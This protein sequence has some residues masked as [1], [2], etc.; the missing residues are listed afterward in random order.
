MNLRVMTYNIQHAMEHAA[1]LKDKTEIINFDMIA[2]VIRRFN[3]DVVGLN[4]VRDRGAD[5]DYREQTL[6][7]ARRLGYEHCYFAKAIDFGYG[8]YGNAIISKYPMQSARTIAI[9]DP[10]YKNSGGYYETRCILKAEFEVP[11]RFDVLISHFGLPAS[12]QRNAVS[13]MM[14]LLENRSVPT[15]AMGD[16][17]M[18]PENPTLAP[19]LAALTDTAAWL[20]EGTMTF[21]TENP[22]IKIDYVL[23][24]EEF[25]PISAQ[26]PAIVASDHCPYIVD[27]EI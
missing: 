16:Y 24:S 13:M 11:T 9:P 6:E 14:Q 18:K 4:E 2:D 23:V 10:V 17:N 7:I 8:P 21:P 15:V 27:L 20:P 25:R 19:L 26:A 22:K 5:P 3:P 12:E 1:W